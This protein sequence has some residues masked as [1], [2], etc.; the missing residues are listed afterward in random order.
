[1]RRRPPWL[2][3]PPYRANA[4]PSEPAGDQQ[5]GN[6][7]FQRALV[8]ALVA[9][10]I[11]VASSA[12]PAADQAMIDARVKIFGPEN[13]DA[14]TGAIKKDKVVFSWPPKW[15][16]GRRRHQEGQGRPLMARAH[17]RGRVAGGTRYHGGY[18]CPAPR[19][20]PG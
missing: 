6:R 9:A 11:A 17:E 8:R 2:P 4:Q 15:R 7:H 5:M 20:H 3:R 10:G 18:L 14:T 1:R 13:V 12:A 19:G 16:R